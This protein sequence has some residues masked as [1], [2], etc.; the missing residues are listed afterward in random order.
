[1]T[2]PASRF[3][4]L[5][6][7]M[8]VAGCVI[9]PSVGLRG[10]YTS[11]DDSGVFVFRGDGTFGYKIAAQFDFYSE[12]NLPP[13]RGRYR[14]HGR[15]VE[16]FDLPTAQPKLTVELLDDGMSFILIRE[17]GNG[18]SAERALYRKQP[19]VS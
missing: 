3:L 12:N 9:Q 11:K 16:L 2:H 6:I 10:K 5:G 4:F 19:A 14:I 13:Y 1:M 7:T 18:R 17:P 15:Q 8:I